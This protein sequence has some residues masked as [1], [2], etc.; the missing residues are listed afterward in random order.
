MKQSLLIALICILLSASACSG[1]SAKNRP[2]LVQNGAI[3]ISGQDFLSDRVIEL[4]GY[5][6]F[7]YGRLLEPRDFKKP[8]AE[9]PS[10]IKVPN[11]WDSFIYNG[12]KIGSFGAST[13]RL[14]IYTGSNDPLSFKIM[15]PNCT[16]KIWANGIFYGE[17]GKV[18]QSHEDEVP[19]YQ[20]KI[21]SFRP[22]NKQIELVIQVS[23]HSIYLGGITLPVSAGP[24]ENL[25]NEKT[26]RIAFDVFIFASLIVISIYYSGLFL[27]R[28]SDRSNIFFSIFTLLLAAR[29]LVTNEMFFYQIFPHADWQLVYKIDFLATTLCVPIFIYFIYLLYPV[30]VNKYIRKIFV[31]CSAIYSFMIIFL[32]TGIYSF[33]LP[34]YNIITIM[35]CI[36]IVHVLILAVRDRQ[37]GANL[38]LSG[39]IILFATVINDVL[40]VNSI[41][42]TMQLSSLGVFAFILLQSLISSMKFA[43]AYMRIEELSHNLEIKVRVRTEELEQE[44]EL[45]RL[46]NDTIEKELVIAMKIQE[47]IIPRFSPAE[48]IYAF[49]KPMDKVGGDFYDFLKFRDTDRIGIF[50][51]DVS[52]HGVPA[53]FIT[54]MIKTAILQA[55]TDRDD[56]SILLSSLNELLVNQTGGNYITAF[57]G[58]YDPHSR[59]LVF[60]NSGHNP[61]YIINRGGVKTIEGYKSIPLAIT[62][63]GSPEAGNRPRLNNTITLEKGD[64]ILFYTDGLTEALSK[65]EHNVYFEEMLVNELLVKYSH[66]SPVDY[67]TSIY[68]ELVNFHGTEL[69]NDDVCMICMDVE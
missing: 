13:Y 22:V 66:Q 60:S 25:Y 8:G 37:E 47:Q 44:K 17:C 2:P 58:I 46:R 52:G 26:S 53:A 29:S 49:Y 28:K 31:L 18:G 65:S 55:G 38:A 19:E 63:S 11:A 48:N 30:A 56:P 32:P 35:A 3:D 61:P 50:L 33:Y 15:P 42:H 68:K 7:Y 14:N 59:E 6:E 5:W 24:A 62:G 9:K 64:K 20:L 1:D 36:L 12:K 54:S 40:S 39:F 21:Y 45:L 16:Y 67:I 10:Y 4:N 34:V 57:Y 43:N 27:M 69:F 51:S 41:I 23:N